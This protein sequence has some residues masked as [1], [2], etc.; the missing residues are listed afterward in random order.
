MKKVL[1]ALILMCPTVVHAQLSTNLISMWQLDNVNDA[2]VA[3]ANNLTNNNTVTFV[4]GLVGNCAN[5]VAAS[6]QSLSIADN[7]SISVGGGVGFAIGVWANFATLPTSGGTMQLAGKFENTAGNRA[8]ILDVSENAGSYDVRMLVRDS[9]D[10]SNAQAVKNV[11][12]TTGTWHLFWGQWNAGDA[13]I[14]I[15]VDNSA[16]TTTAL[17]GGSNDDGS[18]LRFGTLAGTSRFLNGKEDQ[19]MFYKG[20]TIPTAGDRTAI[21]NS[22]LA[23]SYLQVTSQEIAPDAVSNSGYKTASS[24]YSFTH[25]VN[26]PITEN[27]YLTVGVS[28]LSIMGSSVSSVTYNSI[29]MAFIGAVASVS[30]AVRTE[31]WG[32]AAPTVG[33]NSVTV[34]LSTGIDSASGAVSFTGTKQTSSTEGLNTAT[35]TNVGAADATVNVTTVADNDWVIDNVA[36]DD[37][38][39]TVGTGQVQ[40]TNVTGTLGSGAMSTEG[41]KTPAG[42]VTMSWTNVAALATWSTAAVALKPFDTPAVS[43]QTTTKS[44]M[45]FGK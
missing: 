42:S 31:L 30:G 44:L 8:W 2:V 34:T 16:L 21:Y 14:G 17:A 45:G 9:A 33:S 11:A 20:S 3:S 22:G 18:P 41:P 36:T 7:A 37:T 29:S 24:S 12:L 25:V 38:A 35:A 1:I 19:I 28:M 26:S 10:A 15:S 6:S 32:L 13:L 23:L 27:T 40:R 43:G 5:M 4:S 39:I